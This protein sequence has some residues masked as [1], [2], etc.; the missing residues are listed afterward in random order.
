M[1]SYPLIAG[2]S[3]LVLVGLGL[4]LWK[5]TGGRDST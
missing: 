5:W 1:S 3:G 2:G 4:Y